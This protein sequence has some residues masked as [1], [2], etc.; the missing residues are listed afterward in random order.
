MT[1]TPEQIHRR[2]LEM[3][4]AFKG[5]TTASLINA[6][7]GILGIS[8]REIQIAIQEMEREAG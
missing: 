1:L 5:S 2:Y 6:T 3:K 4:S 7:A 8:A